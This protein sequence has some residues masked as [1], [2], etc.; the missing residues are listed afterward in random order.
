MLIRTYFHLLVKLADGGRHHRGREA[1]CVRFKDVKR[2]QRLPDHLG[3]RL[4]KGRDPHRA[5]HGNNSSR[6]QAQKQ[7]YFIHFDG[8]KGTDDYPYPH[9]I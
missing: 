1:V 6:A 3:C 5:T 8:G 7:N 4:S 9:G 2:G